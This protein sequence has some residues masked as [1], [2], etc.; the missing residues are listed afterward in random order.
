M[1]KRR[2]RLRW[3]WPDE[4]PPGTIFVIPA[5]LEEVRTPDRLKDLQWVNLFEA[6]GYGKLVRAL[7]LRASALLLTKEE[8]EQAER[9]EAS[10][11]NFSRPGLLIGLFPNLQGVLNRNAE[12]KA[13]G[14][15]LRQ[16]PNLVEIVA[17]AG[18]GKT[19][20]VRRVVSS[21]TDGVS[22]FPESGLNLLAWIDCQIGPVTSSI[23]RAHLNARSSPEQDP[24]A[25]FF[26]AL[27]MVGPSWWIF[28]NF[29]PNQ[30][31]ARGILKKWC[32]YNHRGVAIV[33]SR[34]P[35]E[36][37]SRADQVPEVQSGL[38]NGLETRYCV[39][40]L[41]SALPKNVAR[42]VSNDALAALAN[43]LHRIPKA[44]EAAASYI[45]LR[46]FE[47]SNWEQFLRREESDGKPDTLKMAADALTLISDSLA[48]L[49]SD[50][51][52]WKILERLSLVQGGL[53]LS[54][55]SDLSSLDE[56]SLTELVRSLMVKIYL[57]A[58]RGRVLEVHPLVK[59]AF[60]ARFQPVPE[61]TI[62]ILNGLAQEALK[63][64]NYEAADSLFAECV[65]LVRSRPPSAERERKGLFMQTRT[66]NTESV[67]ESEAALVFFLEQRSA[68]LMLGGSYGLAAELQKET[69]K[70][71]DTC[72]EL[73]DSD[74]LLTRSRVLRDQITCL[75]LLEQPEDAAKVELEM[76]GILRRLASRSV[77]DG[78]DAYH[79]A[80][81]R[82]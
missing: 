23:L 67:A 28:D 79:S 18:F 16:M 11:F 17:P 25:A 59:E 39:Q 22:I 34:E 29:D 6:S 3:T 14:S 5:R 27:S 19:S 15:A 37:G 47:I 60:V 74:V 71:L 1:F 41:R 42:E 64:R 50:S 57:D 48:Y 38:R 54:A 63:N 31:D 32:Q 58:R 30:P 43:Q 44:V 36:L 73:P 68:A 10:F 61:R 24:D 12:V 80:R 33:L 49:K 45:G 4:K 7:Q 8:R 55:F 52:Q 75:R 82:A 65:R 62:E 56:A 40:M 69:L 70:I 13:L 9:R 21:V 76:L 66:A 81:E 46:E 72:R 78:D 51:P 2:S 77:R 26:T 53:P 35:T 20:I